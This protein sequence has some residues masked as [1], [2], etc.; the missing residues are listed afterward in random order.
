MGHKITHIEL[1]ANDHQAAA[2]FYEAVFGWQTQEFPGMNYT[3]FSASEGGPSG[4]LNPI[5]EGNPAGTTV[6]YIET[7]DVEASL[8]AVEAHGGQRLMPPTEVPGVGTI[9]QFTDP[10]GNRMALLKHA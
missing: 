1:S 2:R 5:Q 6:V 8:A 4:G 9:A 7:D 10:T 3:T